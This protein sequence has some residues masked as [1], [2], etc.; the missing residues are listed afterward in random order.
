MISLLLTTLLSFSESSVEKSTC[1]L[2]DSISYRNW[3]STE[4]RLSGF[5]N[6]TIPDSTAEVNRSPKEI[7]TEIRK[8]VPKVNS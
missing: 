6:D 8:I 4:Y 2:N 1:T 5:E 7:L 3:K